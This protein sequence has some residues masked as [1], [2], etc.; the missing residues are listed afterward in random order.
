MSSDCEPRYDETGGDGWVT[1]VE[2]SGGVGFGVI[3]LG[4]MYGDCRAE[5][6]AE[7]GGETREGEL[8]GDDSIEFFK[9]GEGKSEFEGAWGFE[10]PL[11]VL[12]QEVEILM[13]S[14]IGGS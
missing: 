2:F 10:M 12:L 6:N 4:D 11:P 7:D 9:F 13:V 14:P 3:A 5:T 8:Y 1:V